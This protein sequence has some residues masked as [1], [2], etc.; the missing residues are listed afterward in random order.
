LYVLTDSRFKS[1]E[2]YVSGLEDTS[3]QNRSWKEEISKGGIFLLNGP[4][5]HEDPKPSLGFL[6]ALAETRPIVSRRYSVPTTQRPAY[7][8]IIEIEPDSIHEGVTRANLGS[9]LSMGDAS[10][11]EQLS[12]FYQIEMDRGAGPR[13]SSQ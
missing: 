5:S 1:A 11:S 9:T 8:E 10:V 13:E 4:E 2:L 7:A 6:R 12:G 3:R